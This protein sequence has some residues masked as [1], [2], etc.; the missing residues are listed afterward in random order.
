MY[1]EVSMSLP[2]VQQANKMFT[3]VLI[4]Q[5]VLALII[6]GATGGGWIQAIVLSAIIVAVPIA[7]INS[8]PDDSVT[9]HSV[10]IAV[11]LMTALHIQLSYGMTEL[12]FEIFVLLAF[13]GIYRDW[14]VIAT[15]VAVVA[16]HHVLFFIMQY[17]G[18]STFVAFE[19]DRLSF[20]ILV[21]HAVFAVA[22]GLLLMWIAQ[23]SRQEAMGA[24][25]LSESVHN[26]MLSEDT[27]DLTAAELNEDT[28]E[29]F[30]K[31]ITSLKA[32]I[33]EA[34]STSDQAYSISKTVEDLSLQ[35][36]DAITSNNHSLESI[37][38]AIEQSSLTNKDVAQ[39]ADEANVNA[40]KVREETNNAKQVMS[41]SNQRVEQLREEL[42]DASDTI[43]QLSD[44]CSKIDEAMASIK[45]VSEQTNLLALNAAIESARA[46]EHGRGFAV[47]ADEVRQL[48]TRTGENAE[49]ISQITATLI[50]KAQAS[51]DKMI[52]C[53][54]G[55][56]KSAELAK[57]AATT[58][59]HIADYNQGLD[60]TID[61]V[62][63]ATEEQA[64]VSSDIAN[65][66]QKIYDSSRQQLE[67]AQ[68]SYDGISQ[69]RNAISALNKELNKFVA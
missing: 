28:P 30:A 64:T 24:I 3:Y 65:S 31:L 6:A 41:N 43:Q 42:T 14:K 37:A 8:R 63:M 12:H 13:L 19:E 32:L 57:E 49:E 38:T 47:V 39:R 23:T 9:H 44:M 29:D 5:V 35:L 34:K 4:A 7:L 10:A 45:S 69:L 48:A 62:A 59:N 20:Y 66:T 16:V 21:V 60:D 54:T 15:S 55:V 51:V 46:G 53:I 11:Q 27:F 1:V 56:D 40:S 17:Q 26:I 33:T 61:A 67:H 58:M 25:Q 36:S 2:W 68:H 50:N 18:S 22:E 52:V